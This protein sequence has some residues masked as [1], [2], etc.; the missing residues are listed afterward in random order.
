M[1]HAELV[2]AVREALAD[3]PCRF[4]IDEAVV[5]Q[6]VVMLETVGE[7]NIQR[8]IQRVLKNH[9]WLCDRRAKDVEYTKNHETIS[10]LRKSMDCVTEQ[11]RRGVIWIFILVIALFL[12]FGAKLGL[13]KAGG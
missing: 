12:V 2:S 13:I 8:G 6:L 11:I 4:E 7:G 3:H 10:T 5:Q 1:E 9:E